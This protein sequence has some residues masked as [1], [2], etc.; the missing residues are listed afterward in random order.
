MLPREGGTCAARKKAGECDD[1]YHATYAY[2]ADGISRFVKAYWCPATC[3]RCKGDDPQWR[4]LKQLGNTANPSINPT[5]LVVGGVKIAVYKSASVFTS[6]I[7]TAQS[8]QLHVGPL[9]HVSFPFLCSASPNQA[10]L[11]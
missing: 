11:N 9:Y 4:T 6:Y 1:V 10:A 5:V 2:P 8:P 3:G 7:K